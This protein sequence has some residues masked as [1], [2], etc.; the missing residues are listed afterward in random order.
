MEAGA[1][2]PFAAVNTRVRSSNGIAEEYF[3]GLERKIKGFGY[4]SV[5]KIQ[6]DRAPAVAIRQPLVS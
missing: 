2:G 3:V 5:P 6:S 1:E 4:T